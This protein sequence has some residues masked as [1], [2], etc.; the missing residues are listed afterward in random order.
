MRLLPL[1]LILAASLAHAGAGC[2][3]QDSVPEADRLA[4]TL[5]WTT[6][7]E[8]DNFG[9]DVFRGLAEEG[10]FKKLTNAP[11]LGHGTTDETNDY[12]YSDD[13]IDPCK[14]YWYYVESISTSGERERFTPVFQAKPKLPA[15][16][17]ATKSEH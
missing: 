14:S 9:Y 13:S 11:M 16:G 5:K 2:G 17:T 4:N 6:A 10:P 12:T 15:A 3:P 8:Q 1:I 7:S